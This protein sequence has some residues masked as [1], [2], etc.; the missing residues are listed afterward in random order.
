MN[1]IK[2]SSYLP[3]TKEQIDR[4]KLDGEALHQLVLDYRISPSAKM[5]VITAWVQE[6][7]NIFAPLKKGQNNVPYFVVGHPDKTLL[8]SF[9][10]GKW[11]D[12]STR[13]FY[14][15]L[16]MDDVDALSFF[17]D[18]KPPLHRLDVTVKPVMHHRKWLQVFLEEGVGFGDQKLTKKDIYDLLAD[19]TAQEMIEAFNYIEQ[20]KNQ[21]ITRSPL[22]KHI[23][24]VNWKDI[25]EVLAGIDEYHEVVL[26][27]VKDKNISFKK[28][29]HLHFTPNIFVPLIQQQ[30]NVIKSN[31][32]YDVLFV[33]VDQPSWL[34]RF[35]S[36]L[37][38]E[39]VEAIYHITKNK[40]MTQGWEIF[41][42]NQNNSNGHYLKKIIERDAIYQA[43]ET[44]SYQKDNSSKRKM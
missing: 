10:T 1:H 9:W 8:K 31:D 30:L 24:K 3:P 41:L 35:F 42:S 5:K 34:S 40:N 19:M 16:E 6:G 32:L 27:L 15:A 2:I 12:M 26:A 38:N 39:D 21:Y 33:S 23:Y 28:L 11:D 13:L 36:S 37:S 7:A 22:K 18:K 25:V 14:T 43:V 44:F 4:A 29:D 20:H 17:M